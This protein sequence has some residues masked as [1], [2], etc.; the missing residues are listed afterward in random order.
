MIKLHRDVLAHRREPVRWSQKQTLYLCV[1]CW[2]VSQRE[3]MIL[4]QMCDPNEEQLEHWTMAD[5]EWWSLCR[6]LNWSLFDFAWFASLVSKWVR[7]NSNQLHRWL[8]PPRIQGNC[9][10][11]VWWACKLVSW[12]QSTFMC[13]MY[14][15]GKC[16]QKP[17]NAEQW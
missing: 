8:K 14:L 2:H 11:P 3:R 13:N 1:I 17:S 12:G 16:N 9:T 6:G 5:V 10:K 4:E 7:T 15:V